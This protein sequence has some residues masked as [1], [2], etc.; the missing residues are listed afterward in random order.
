M[1]VGCACTRVGKF[2]LPPQ[3]AEVNGS[4]ALLQS[5][6]DDEASLLTSCIRWN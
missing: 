4:D 5:N 3:G 1:K 2:K 6:N